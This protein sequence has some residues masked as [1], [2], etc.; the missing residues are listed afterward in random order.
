MVAR[1]HR[2]FPPARYLVG[3][4]TGDS[5]EQAEARARADLVGGIEERVEQE[6]QIRQPKV[7]RAGFSAL[8]FGIQGKLVGEPA[9]LQVAVTW[10]SSDGRR[11]ATM[12]TIERQEIA[13]AIA[14]QIREYEA[15]CQ[16]LV[17]GITKNLADSPYTAVLNLLAAL[18]LRSQAEEQRA[19]LAAVSDDPP[20]AS[21]GSGVGQLVELFET[22]LAAIELYAA[23]GNGL[24]VRADATGVALVLGVDWDI[25]GTRQPMARMPVRFEIPEPGEECSIRSRVDPAGMATVGIASVRSFAGSGFEVLARIDGTQLL[26]DAGIEIDDQRFTGLI[27]MIEKP[28]A[29]FRLDVTSEKASRVAVIV[30]ETRAGELLH[31]SRVGEALGRLLTRAGFHVIDLEEL[32]V[33]IPANPSP[34]SMASL[35]AGKADMLIYGVVTS[36][37]DKAVT[38]GLV[39]ARAK[40]HLIAVQ[41]DTKKT[42]AEIQPTARSAGRDL[43][44]ASDRA[45][46]LLSRKAFEALGSALASAAGKPGEP[47]Q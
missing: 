29:R 16:Q 27:D 37:V 35:V 2:D 46:E 9:G 10:S 17:T 47:E 38:A 45:F 18:L 22:M 32:Q 3:I 30:A 12:A 34:E 4:G 43:A 23:R 5:V 20:P 11:H 24:A 8:R 15:Q 41:V 33:Q 6:I 14:E 26:R 19:L 13:A 39:F 31:D 36:E 40:G 44:S 42:L 7:T 1:Q 28:V 25:G 21:R